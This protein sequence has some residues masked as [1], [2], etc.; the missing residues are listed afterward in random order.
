MKSTHNGRVAIVT[1]AAR[2]IGQAIAVKLAD[3]GAKLVLF[4]ADEADGTARR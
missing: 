4:D 3:I 1:G 2:G